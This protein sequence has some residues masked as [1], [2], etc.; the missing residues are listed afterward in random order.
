MDTLSDPVIV[1][2]PIMFNDPVILA[3]PVNGN[4]APPPATA[5]AKDAVVANEAVAALIS[6]P[7]ICD[8]LAL[9]YSLY[10]VPISAWSK[11]HCPPIYVC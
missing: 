6:K 2:E 11:F 4:A 8:I 1:V 9:I 7:F 5:K 10:F 3:D